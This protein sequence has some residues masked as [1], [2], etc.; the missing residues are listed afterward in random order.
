V[1]AFRLGI[2]DYIIKPL[3]AAELTASI[4][5]AL[6][7]SR[8]Q[9]ERDRLV[10]QLMHSNSQLQRRAQELNELYDVG[11]TV[12]SSLNLEEVL[13]RV[14]ESAVHVVGAEEGSLMLLDEDRSELYIRASKN[15]D[16]DARSTRRRVTDSLAGQVLQRQEPIAIGNNSPLERT[17]TALLVK[18]L[19]YVP[20]ILEGEAIG[21]LGV[22]N[23]RQ[24][25]SF[26]SDDIRALS[27]LAGY[28]TIA[29]HNAN[30]FNEIDRERSLLD[31]VVNQN[32]DPVLM[33]DRDNQILLMNRSAQA[34]FGQSE[35]KVLTRSISALIAL[36]AL[37]EFLVARDNEE[38]IKEGEFIGHDG[39][40][41]QVRIIDVDGGSRYIRLRRHVA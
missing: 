29:I 15:L 13:Q 4:D 5:N 6:R 41:I 20:L 9:R 18:A 27:A 39:A 19:I 34:F 1:K 26:D 17:H 31:A 36:P 21:V 33:I 7:E 14:V 35:T 23:Y 32:R 2:R 37:Y 3:D 30:M 12:S 22:M 10:D 40:K 38:S 8:L 16:S 11:K 24:E 28:A 25:S